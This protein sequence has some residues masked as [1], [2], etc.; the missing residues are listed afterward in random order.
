MSKGKKKKAK[1]KASNPTEPHAKPT[2]KPQP[3]PRNAPEPRSVPKPAPESQNVPE[4]ATEPAPEPQNVPESATEPGPE[5]QNVPESATEPGP[6][7]GSV[8]KPA[9]EPTSVPKP[10]PESQNVPESATE[11]GPETRHEKEDEKPSTSS[12]NFLQR[13]HNPVHPHT[14]SM[15]CCKCIKRFKFHNCRIPEHK[16]LP[17][18]AAWKIPAIACRGLNLKDLAFAVAKYAPK[19]FDSVA[20]PF[21]SCQAP[22]YYLSAKVEK[23]PEIDPRPHYFTQDP[24]PL[25]SRCLKVHGLPERRTQQM[26]ESQQPTTSTTTQVP[27]RA[28][29]PEPSPGVQEDKEEAVRALKKAIASCREFLDCL[30]EQQA[31][32]VQMEVMLREVGEGVPPNGEE[33]RKA[34]QAG[35]AEELAPGCSL[36]K[37]DP[38]VAQV[39]KRVKA[40]ASALEAAV[41][42]AAAVAVEIL[43]DEEADIQETDITYRTVGQ[44]IFW[45]SLEY[46]TQAFSPGTKMLII[47]QAKESNAFGALKETLAVFEKLVQS[48]IE[49]RVYLKHFSRIQ[50][51]DKEN[52]TGVSPKPEQSDEHM[53]DH[54]QNEKGHTAAAQ[55]PPDQEA[56]PNVDSQ[57]KEL[58]TLLMDF[59]KC[60]EEDSLLSVPADVLENPEADSPEQSQPPKETHL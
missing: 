33:T 11:P 45:L 5:P 39:A 6:E 7:P 41:E 54:G 55:M 35:P 44:R 20:E 26:E 22:Y 47:S 48:I 59:A 58:V 29:S 19:S 38:R 32:A 17:P 2:P 57:I 36:N 56:N 31:C 34:L 9:P 12:S 3:E 43:L 1:A 25:C 21:T 27:A 14:E 4:S 49:V 15:K 50:M 30:E 8:P 24:Q 42:A 60:L 18:E 52:K 16:V 37:K 28:P 51:A 23:K 53:F 40:A 10:A 13:S 46:M